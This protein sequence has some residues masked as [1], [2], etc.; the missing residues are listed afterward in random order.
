[1]AELDKLRA[2]RVCREV[3]RQGGFAAAGRHLNISTPSVS[4]LVA[5]LEEHLGVRLFLRSTRRLSL[6]EDGD[7]FLD[8]ACALV[9]ELDVI[10]DE[11]RERRSVPRGHLRVS[12]V[13][14]FGQERIAP[15]IPGFLARYPEVTIELEL[16][17]R[18]VDL[19]QE[20]I[21]LAIRVGNQNGLKASALTAR[22]IYSQRLIFVA[23][24]EYI[25]QHGAPK[26]LEDVA[27]HP[28]VK[29][30]SGTW[31]EVNQLENG[32]SQTD[33]RM[34]DTFVVNSPNAAVNAVKSGQVIGLIGD[35]LVRDMLANGRLQRLLPDFATEEQLI[36][37]VFVHRTYM[38]AKLRCFID[39][40]IEALGKRA[41][42]E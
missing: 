34:P 21:D 28:T 3:A 35:Y 12:S 26:N 32:G 19:I 13:V 4:R 31:G 1:M 17:N 15:L 33:F 6:T 25:H 7:A 37:A 11:L 30:I 36:H 10:S 23:T 42:F 38:P 39:H 27:Q 24:P 8:R 22:K 20:N 2:I 9:D 41:D 5:E 29:Q 14:A 40:M 18:N 16:E